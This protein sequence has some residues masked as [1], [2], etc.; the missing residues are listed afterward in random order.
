MDNKEKKIWIE[1]CFTEGCDGTSKLLST[2][3]YYHDDDSVY[4]SDKY[5]C[6]N[7]DLIWFS[8]YPII[9]S[10]RINPIQRIAIQA[11][12]DIRG[13][14]YDQLSIGVLGEVQDI[15]TLTQDE[16]TKIIEYGNNLDRKDQN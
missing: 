7:C 9:Y 5:L 1:K 3:Y 8:N 14:K 10:N 11:L 4:A 13:Y 15:N 12:G 6:E 16:A 2:E